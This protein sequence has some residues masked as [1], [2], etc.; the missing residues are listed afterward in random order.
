QQRAR[1]D[2]PSGRRTWLRMMAGVVSGV[3]AFR[4]LGP[5]A[6][7]ALGQAQGGRGARGAG[8]DANAA[9]DNKTTLVLLGTQA[10]PGVGLA[11]SQT[12]SVVLV[13]GQ[14]Y[15]VDCG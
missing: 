9:A 12:A 1:R 4:L 7:T 8:A 5:G 14:P 13:G 10:G 11:R 15:L 6:T 2:R 3:G